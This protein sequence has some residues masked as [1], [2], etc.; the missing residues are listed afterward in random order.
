MSLR[1]SAIL[2]LTGALLM[3]L[4]TVRAYERP[5]LPKV[6][7]HSL[8]DAELFARLDP[9]HPAMA[10]VLAVYEKDG[11]QAGK[12]A[13]ADYFRAR[14]EPYWKVDPQTR[15][16][17]KHTISERD[18]RYAE[19]A[20]K[21]YFDRRKP[22]HQF[23]KNIDWLD[24]PTYDKKYEFDKEWSMGFLRMP[25]WD[26]LGTAYWATGDEKYA[27]E[28]VDQF[29][30]FRQDHPIP[31]QGCGW[32]SSHPLKY[33]VPEWRTLETSIRVRGSWTNAF[34]HLLTSPSLDDDALVEML[35][36]F[37]EMGDYLKKFTRVEGRT[38]NWTTS[39]LLALH[40]DGALF[41]EFR[42][43]KGWRDYAAQYM[44]KEFEKQVYPD[45][46]QWELA[47]GYG[48][49]V[50]KQFRGLVDTA[51]LAGDTLP[52]AYMKRL[53]GMYNYFLYSSVNGRCPAFGDS[54]HGSVGSLMRLA[55]KDFPK[56]ADFQW[57]ASG[58]KKGETPENLTE[59]W[60]WAG[61]YAM[62]SGWDKNDRFM[63]VDAGP[64]GVSHQN[65]DFLNF[66]MFAY[67]DYLI[68]DAGSY[69]YNYDSPWR[70]HMTGS[71]SHSTLVV[72][73]QSQN[74]R[75]QKKLWTADKPQDHVFDTGDRFVY[76]QG[77]YNHGYGDKAA[78]K[79]DHTRSIFFIDNRYWVIFDRAAPKDG[80][81]HLYETLL[82][83]NTDKAEATGGRI[84]TQRDK[85]PNLLVAVAPQEGQEISVAK[86]QME[87]VRRG[88]KKGGTTVV[89]H[90]MGA[91]GL[92]AKGAARF[93]ML[94]YPVEPG[95]DIPAT[96]RIEFVEASGGRGAMAARVVVPGRK[97]ILVA[98]QLAEGAMRVGE[99]RV[100]AR[101]ALW[102]E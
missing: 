28:I 97:P 35:K 39:Q 44:W 90:P 1:R 84:V 71:L 47:P 19:S 41:P 69:R 54:G 56:R 46:V 86:G 13:L 36:A 33:K 74:R 95:K 8:T 87:P 27:K 24:N 53:E 67:G 43:A 96:G 30:D 7:R 72:D 18:Q 23:G 20:M 92:R 68:V 98:D 99:K 45:G 9:A 93:A 62:R 76:F 60:P 64:Y 77:T 75:A 70:D 34:F 81:E 2:I 65:E 100:A 32:L 78:I 61:Q 63:I 101:R 12:K 25:W 29:L 49:G 38:N 4:A 16:T 82:R 80:G 17:K 55:A 57:A 37:W 26:S 79:V 66:E 94:L 21:H 52:E 15:T 88:W 6:E 83:V 3:P 102:D 51:K 11:V 22:H 14:K 40:T 31:T 48:A 91:V 59:A 50:T 58:G 73:H 89:P 42:E 5:P 85:G 10:E